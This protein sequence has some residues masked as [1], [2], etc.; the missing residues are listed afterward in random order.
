VGGG[1]GGGDH[2]TGKDAIAPRK[3]KVEGTR[4]RHKGLWQR[5]GECQEKIWS[6]RWNPLAF[7]GRT[8]AVGRSRSWPKKGKRKRRAFGTNNI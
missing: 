1:P 4:T 6:P 7:R 8:G 2:T 5:F 3:K